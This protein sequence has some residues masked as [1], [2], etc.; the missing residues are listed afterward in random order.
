VL[1]L[2]VEFDDDGAVVSK[3]PTLEKAPEPAIASIEALLYGFRRPKPVDATKMPPVRRVE[4]VD[5]QIRNFE[6]KFGA[7]GDQQRLSRRFDLVGKV[8][9]A[10]RAAPP[11]F[12]PL[13]KQSCAKAG[14]SSASG[15]TNPVTRAAR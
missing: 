12:L 13:A 6:A 5:L 10:R 4:N 15:E 3:P 7:T 9:P 2:A 14:R 8:Q 11:R 1:E